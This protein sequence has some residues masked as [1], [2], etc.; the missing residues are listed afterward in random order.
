MCLERRV[1]GNI[2]HFLIYTNEKNKYVLGHYEYSSLEAMVNDFRKKPVKFNIKLR[3][4]VTPELVARF[5]RVRQF[6]MVKEGN[7]D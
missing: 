5:C 2:E 1:E 7:G 6:C 4:P 3:Y